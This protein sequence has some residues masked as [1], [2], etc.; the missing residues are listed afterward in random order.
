PYSTHFAWM[1]FMMVYSRLSTSSWLQLIRSE[2]WLSSRPETAT[3]PALAALA[4]PYRIFALRNSCAP[5][6]SVGIFAPSQTAF[7]PFFNSN[8]ASSPLSSFF[9]AQGNTT[10]QGTDQG[11]WFSWNVT[12]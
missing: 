12:L 1:S 5:S 6:S 9:V 4:G 7:T 2:F 10:S 3:P 11:L 8:R